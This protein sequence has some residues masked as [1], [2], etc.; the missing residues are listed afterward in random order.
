MRFELRAIESLFTNSK[1]HCTAHGKIITILRMWVSRASCSH[2]QPHGQRVEQE[3][4]LEEGVLGGPSLTRLSSSGLEE[5]RGLLERTWEK[6]RGKETH[7]LPKPPA[8]SLALLGHRGAPTCLA[9]AA[10][11]SLKE[12]RNRR[13]RPGVCPAQS[14]PHHGRTRGHSTFLKDQASSGRA[15]A[16]RSRRR[17]GS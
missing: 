11:S 9:K 6:E 12:S 7:L 13:H 2:N 15:V 5:K 14:Q 1:L 17:E 10:M 16:G 4:L 8:T 3:T